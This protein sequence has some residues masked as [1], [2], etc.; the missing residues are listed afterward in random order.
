[1]KVKRARKFYKINSIFGRLLLLIFVIGILVAPFI[2]DYT[3]FPNHKTLYNVLAMYSSLIIFMPILLFLVITKNKIKRQRIGN[4]FNIYILVLSIMT[5]VGI[6]IAIILTSVLPQSPLPEEEKRILI[7]T[8]AVLLVVVVIL[9][10]LHKLGSKYSKFIKSVEKKYKEIKKS[11]LPVEVKNDLISKLNNAYLENDSEALTAIVV[12]IIEPSSEK[13]GS[14]DISTKSY[15][16]DHA[17]PAFFA[18]IGRGFI[19]AITLG[20]AYPFVLCMKIGREVKHTKYDGKAM[21]FDGNG[22]QLIGKWGLW[23]LLSVITFGIYAFFIPNRINKWV[24]KHTHFKGIETD[25]KG[26]YTGIFIVNLLLKIACF[27]LNICTIFILV[28]FTTCWKYGYKINH[29]IYDGQRLIFKGNGGK[30]IGK[31]IIWLLLCIPTFGIFI[32]FLP[33]RIKIWKISQTHYRSTLAAVKEAKKEVVIKEEA[34]NKPVYY[35][36]SLISILRTSTTF[37][38]LGGIVLIGFVFNNSLWS[39]LKEPWKIE[40]LAE[41]L[42]KDEYYSISSLEENFPDYV[43][44]SQE[45][46]YE[47]DDVLIKINR[48]FKRIEYIKDTRNLDSKEI[49]S[50]EILQDFYSTDSIV[51]IKVIYSDGSFIYDYKT[52]VLSLS[53]SENGSISNI[54]LYDSVGN[55]YETQVL[56]HGGNS[57]VE[58]DNINYTFKR[59][60]DRLVVEITGNGT[61]DLAKILDIDVYME[62]YRAIYSDSAT[63]SVDLVIGE[64]ITSIYRSEPLHTKFNYVSFPSTLKV[65]GDSTFEDVQ[66]I[67]PIVL[68][69]GLLEI[70]D[71]SFESSY[72]LDIT[73]P[74][75]L[76]SIG[77]RAFAYN[78]LKSLTIPNSV[79]SIGASILYDSSLLESLKTPFL[80]SKEITSV[81]SASEEELESANLLYLIG[82]SSYESLPSLSYVEVDRGIIYENAFSR[83]NITNIVL[84]NVKSICDSAFSGLESLETLTINNDLDYIGSYAIRNTNI[85]VL[86]LN[87]IDTI[88]DYAFADSSLDELYI[89][90]DVSYIGECILKNVYLDIL[91]IPYLGSTIDDKSNAYLNYLFSGYRYQN[92]WFT[93]KLIGD[94]YLTKAKH[95]GYE[96]FYQTYFDNLY[97]PNTLESV[98]SSAFYL[99]SSDESYYPNVFYDGDISDYLTIERSSSMHED[100]LHFFFKIDGQYQEVIDLVIPEGTKEVGAYAFADFNLRSVTLNE[101]LETIST[102]A[103]D[104]INLTTLNIPNSVKVIKSYAFYNATLSNLYMPYVESLDSGILYLAEIGTLTIAGDYN[105]LPD[106]FSNITAL[107]IIF[108]GN[109]SSVVDESFSYSEIGKMILPDGV[110][111]IGERAFENSTIG[112][113]RLPNTLLEIGKE[114]FENCEIAEVV[115]PNSLKAIPEYLFYNS[116]VSKVTLP[117]ALETIG[118]YAFSNSNITDLVIPDTLISY[119]TGGFGTMNSL[120]NLTL[121]FIAKDSSDITS[122]SSIISNRQLDTL[123][124][125]GGYISKDTFTVSRGYSYSIKNVILDNDVIATSDYFVEILDVETLTLIGEFNLSRLGLYYSSNDKDNNSVLDSLRKVIIY[126]PNIT[127]SFFINTP[128]EEVIIGEGVLTIEANAFENTNLINVF[129]SDTVTSI[130]RGAFR[131]C[132]DIEEM[133]LPFVGGSETNNEYFAYIF[134]AISNNSQADYMPENLSKVTITNESVL[135]DQMFKGI[136]LDYLVILSEVETIPSSFL[137][138]AD[139]GHLCLV[140]EVNL[141]NDN[142]YIYNENP[143][144]AGKYWTYDENGEIVIKEI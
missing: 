63:V 79:T 110:T 69:E 102:Y 73:L 43:K 7:I 62:L 25:E 140:N 57:S 86:E 35:Q 135:D 134:G 137:T 96:A 81:D 61:A 89:N 125:N 20:F 60:N 6:I 90:G 104:S 132:A 41:E 21:Y 53:N 47:Y 31:W 16:D 49:E 18:K 32:L 117:N 17:I 28:P 108:E 113:L 119:P 40:K 123:I 118:N 12:P 85:K 120:N 141:T 42:L 131:N 8:G 50:V 116:T 45:Y 109:F 93:E 124:V 54:S 88:N 87:N 103:F 24:A 3:T 84:N 139:I 58:E 9:C 100:V 66:I 33:G 29:T 80:G 13:D 30:L 122:L 111:S 26:D 56:V 128:I 83:A 71:N 44:T 130:A 4:G 98:S 106:I 78:Y 59:D 38:V 51:S 121:P 105:T 76:V 143:I 11:E 36:K 101:G 127:E 74:S 5:F 48:D 68:P 70:G 39:N 55:Y 97:L 126:T 22:G 136:T 115:L 114:A 107:E 14:V 92:G 23:I 138:S 1:M 72:I 82:D 94:L 65:I 133:T 34:I 75:T 2:I 91:K 19:L 77:N 144:D 112:E 27:I 64:G 52:E 37:I 142:I 95:L 99:N 67:A 129:V 10:V 46:I 15:Y